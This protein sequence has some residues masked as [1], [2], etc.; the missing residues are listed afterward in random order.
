LREKFYFLLIKIKAMLEYYSAVCGEEATLFQGQNNDKSCFKKHRWTVVTVAGENGDTLW[1][2]SSTKRH[3]VI[4]LQRHASIHA[5]RSIG[6]C[7]P[8]A[9]NIRSI[10]DRLLITSQRSQ[11]RGKT[12]TL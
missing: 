7:G 6:D 12:Q 11:F 10:G 1:Q 8:V 4:C 2:V 5:D 9:L 3:L